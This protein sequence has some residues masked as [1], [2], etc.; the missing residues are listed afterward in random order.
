MIADQE[1]YSTTE[2]V[3]L[4]PYVPLCSEY[5]ALAIRSPYF[6]EYSTHRG[7]GM[8]MPRLR[9]KDAINAPFPL[10]PLKEQ[11]RIVAKV[12][13]LMDLCDQLK[14]AQKTRE[15][16]RANF[17]R[18][19]LLQLNTFDSNEKAFQSN[20]SFALSALPDLSVRTDQIKQLR[21]V[22]L[23][24]AVSGKLVRQNPND[25][26]ASQLLKKI[27]DEKERSP[28]TKRTKCDG[29]NDVSKPPPFPV[30]RNWRWVC[31]EEITTNRGQKIPDI[32][33]TYVDVSA[34]DKECGIV[35]SPRVIQPE[36]APSRARKIA[37]LD[38]VIY[39]CV[40]P[41]LLNIAVIEDI[42]DPPLI[43]STAFEVMNGH[44]YVLPRYI[45]IALRSPYMVDCVE[46]CQRGIA[47]PAIKSTD[48][49][50]LPFPLPP[51]AE[52]HR[53]VAKFNELMAL[54]DQLEENISI[55]NNSRSNLIT[56]ILH[57]A[58]NFG[59]SDPQ[60]Q[61]I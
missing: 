44:G 43:V 60:N 17:T 41:Y 9:T 35:V 51:L 48:F 39:S 46:M 10:P 27:A 6:V 40:R 25:E 7:L 23:S 33:F 50:L 45:W 12:N 2:I 59:V 21:Q 42:F 54:C 14:K 37:E 13:E 53:I 3:A 47:Y 57:E 19:S 32:P 55:S 52:Q 24:F 15:E 30:P 8:K 26:P 56:A 16:I 11:Y 61:H 38:D 1:G 58:L 28:Y 22:I 49:R 4:R 36:N 20:V 31:I 5:C 34:I 18:A 29:F